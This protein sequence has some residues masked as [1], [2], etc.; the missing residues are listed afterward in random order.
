MRMLGDRGGRSRG[1][2]NVADAALVGAL[3]DVSQPSRAGGTVQVNATLETS[4]PG[5]EV[6]A[7]GVLMGTTPIVAPLPAGAALE[8][9]PRLEGHTPQRHLF[10]A[11]EAPQRVT[12]TR[13]SSSGGPRRGLAERHASRR[14]CLR[15]LRLTHQRGMQRIS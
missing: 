11:I 5:A 2:P 15:A 13:A 3:A 14:L 9:E 6:W 8:V 7:D 1:G 12:L 4:P 10:A